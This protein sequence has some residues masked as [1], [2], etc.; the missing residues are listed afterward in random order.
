[1]KSAIPVDLSWCSFLTVSI[2][3]EPQNRSLVIILSINKAEIGLSLLFVIS[4]KSLNV[5]F[6]DHPRG[7]CDKDG[8]SFTIFTGVDFGN[9]T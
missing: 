1:M 9:L 2:D 5:C 7:I 8:T 6:I 4:T 3:I